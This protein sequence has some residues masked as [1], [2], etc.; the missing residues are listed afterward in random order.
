MSEELFKSA[1]EAYQSMLAGSAIL[2]TGFLGID[3]E[4]TANE[5][6]IS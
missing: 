1:K 4:L 2:E 3:S 5:S 6:D